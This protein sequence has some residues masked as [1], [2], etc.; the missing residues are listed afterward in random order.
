MTDYSRTTQ[1]KVANMGRALPT[2]PYMFSFIGKSTY[3]KPT[4]AVIPEMDEGSDL[5]DYDTGDVYIFDRDADTW[6][7]Q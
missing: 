7:L 4:L 6:I 5:Y 1:Y 2:G 3:V